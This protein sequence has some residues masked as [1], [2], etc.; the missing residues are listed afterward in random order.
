MPKP[1]LKFLILLF[2]LPLSACEYEVTVKDKNTDKVIGTADV[3][4]NDS[5]A[6]NPIS[7]PVK[8]TPINIETG[9]Y[10][11]KLVSGE[12]YYGQINDTDADP[13]VIKNVYYNYDQML[14]NQGKNNTNQSGS[15]R[16]V[17][18]GKEPH[19]PDTTMSIIRNQVKYM[20]ALK[21]DS[22]VL[23][24]ILQYEK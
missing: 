19:G 10:A 15:V 22:K 12:T 2:V 17:K 23:Q 1:I 16:L 6:K 11:V 9:W 24:A 4:L 8:S 20:E 14:E 3:R 18:R 5:T 7:N 21:Q 13:V